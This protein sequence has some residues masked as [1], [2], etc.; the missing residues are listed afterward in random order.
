MMCCFSTTL[1]S[2][3]HRNQLNI[4]MDFFLVIFTF[5]IQ[6]RN[7]HIPLSISC[8]CFFVQCRSMNKMF[9]CSSRVSSFF[10]V[11]YRLNYML[12]APSI[13]RH[14]CVRYR[15]LAFLLFFYSIVCSSTHRLIV[16][17]F[18]QRQIIIIIVISSSRK[19][20]QCTYMD[21]QG[22]LKHTSTHVHSLKT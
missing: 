5:I 12:E 13:Y 7:E 6:K 4:S 1:K 3:Y 16:F 8:C 19:N 20:E 10:Y 11:F 2:D 18:F 15:V 17:D 21:V 9:C 22:W 14:V